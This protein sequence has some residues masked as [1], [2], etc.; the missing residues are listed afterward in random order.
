MYYSLSTQVWALA[1]VNMWTI[2]YFLVEMITLWRDLNSVT[3]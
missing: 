3:L 2:C 1:V